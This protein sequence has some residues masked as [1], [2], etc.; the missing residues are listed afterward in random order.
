MTSATLQLTKELLRCESLTPQD[1]GC[2]Q[3]IAARLEKLGFV[4]ESVV[5]QDVTN[6]WAFRPADTQTDDSGLLCFAGH[7]DVVPTGPLEQWKHAPFAAVTENGVLHGRGSADMKGGLAAML[8]AVES[9][10]Q[11]VHKLEHALAFLITSD[12]EGPSQFGTKAMMPWLANRD[13]QIDWCIIGEPSSSK[14]IGDVIRIGRR[15]SLTGY[16]TIK[17]IQGHVA[18]PEKAQNAISNSLKTLQAIDEIDWDTG[19]N[20]FPPSS[21]QIAQ[22]HAGEADNV[23]PG[24]LKAHFNLRYNNLHTY[25]KIQ[26]HIEKIFNA[27]DLTYV[28]EWHLSGEPFLTDRTS[29]LVQATVNAIKQ[30]TGMETDCS[31]GGGTSDGRFI[32]PSGAQVVELGLLNH[33]IHKIDEHVNVSDLDELHQLYLAVIKELFGH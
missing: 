1:A 10:L 25:E 29:K 31:T 5:I 9:F 11:E 15:G 22:I 14:R 7:T 3:I 26:E 18:Y 27:A 33:S 8:T 30:T 32:A 6:L 23:I 2:Q 4:I 19:S 21:L 12:E 17:G 13:I 24:E 16:L 28:L 20:E